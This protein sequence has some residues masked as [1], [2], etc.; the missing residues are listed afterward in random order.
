MMKVNGRVLRVMVGCLCLLGAGIALPGCGYN[1]KPTYSEDYSTIYVPIFKNKT[2]YQGLEFDVTKAVINEIELRTPYKTTNTTTADT[3]LEATIISVDQRLVSRERETG[4]PQDMEFRITLDVTW[5]KSLSDKIIRERKG[6][7]V[8]GRFQP[9]QIVGDTY[10]RG[11]HEAAQ[12]VAG[13]I[14]AMMR[15]DW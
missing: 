15:T 9:T 14:A 5:R 4:L 10:F 6:M 1:T 8:V 2:F 12:K 11:Q 3:T 7:V 13:D